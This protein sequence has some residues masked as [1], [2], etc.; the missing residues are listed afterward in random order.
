LQK[1][2]RAKEFAGEMR[3]AKAVYQHNLVGIEYKAKERK[4]RNPGGKIWLDNQ[5]IADTQHR[6]RPD[7]MKQP[8]RRTLSI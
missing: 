2:Q 6:Q 8:P 3:L 7:Q 4:D 5:P 1:H